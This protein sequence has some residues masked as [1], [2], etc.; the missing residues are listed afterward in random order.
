MTSIYSDDGTLAGILWQRSGVWYAETPMGNARS[1]ASE[2]SARSWLR[3]A[4]KERT[5]R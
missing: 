5:N 4:W 1:F 3:Q 2:Q